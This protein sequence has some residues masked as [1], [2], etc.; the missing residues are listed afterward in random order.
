MRC[1]KKWPS[2]QTPIGESD[3][4]IKRE[5]YLAKDTEQREREE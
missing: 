1:G 2:L 5:F 3:Q 4:E